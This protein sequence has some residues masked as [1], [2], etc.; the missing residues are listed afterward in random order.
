[1]HCLWQDLSPRTI[2]FDL[3][4]LSLKFDLLLKIFNICY[5]FKGGEIGLSCCRCTL[6]VTIPVTPYHKFW[7]CDLDFKV[8]PHLEKALTLTITFKVEEIGISFRI[9]CIPCG[10]TFHVPL[11][12]TVTLKFDLLYHWLLFRDGCHPASVVDLIVTVYE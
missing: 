1:M 9:L 12:L 4:T 3:V 10:K 2:L 7:H 8:W 11:I 5:N 6:L